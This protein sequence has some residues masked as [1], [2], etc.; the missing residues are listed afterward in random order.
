MFVSPLDGLKTAISTVGSYVGQS[1]A[2]LG[3]LNNGALL[4]MWN[5][6][7]MSPVRGI[8]ADLRGKVLDTQRLINN[9]NASMQSVNAKIDELDSWL[10]NNVLVHIRNINAWAAGVQDWITNGITP[11]VSGIQDRVTGAEAGIKAIPGLIEKR[12]REWAEWYAFGTLLKWPITGS[13]YGMGDA[14]DGPYNHHDQRKQMLAPYKIAYNA[15][16]GQWTNT[17]TGD[18]LPP[19]CYV[20]NSR[21]WATEADWVNKQILANAFKDVGVS[22]NLPVLGQL[23]STVSY[24]ITQGT[25]IGKSVDS[26]NSWKTQVTD[27]LGQR[28]TLAQIDSKIA[29][30][31]NRIGTGEGRIGE[32]EN[33]LPATTNA[34]NG[35]IDDANQRVDTAI[36]TLRGEMAAGDQSILSQAQQ[37][38]TKSANSLLEAVNRNIAQGDSNTLSQAQSMDQGVLSQ[39]AE[40]AKAKANAALAAANQTTTD[41]AAATLNAAKQD[42]ANKAN[43]ALAAANQN[44]SA[45]QK[46]V[47]DTMAAQYDNLS[48]RVTKLDDSDAQLAARIR[49]LEVQVEK[50]APVLGRMPKLPV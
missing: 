2:K 44:I 4:D 20:A 7:F 8:I 21:N 17:L 49:N 25:N 35:R 24:A 10:D 46:Q 34:L 28:P 48:A 14:P 50:V 11:W 43:A 12:A 38:A 5:S 19:S 27:A 22:Q 23:W 15:S 42:A 26:L 41:K 6:N 9:V 47:E 1:A 32:L 33:Q 40:D 31:I 16:D 18:K 30:V 39:A 36:S 13:Q 29:G 3:E 37:N 45:V